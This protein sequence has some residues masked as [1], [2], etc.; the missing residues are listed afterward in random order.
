MVYYYAVDDGIEM[1]VA[2]NIYVANAKIKQYVE[3]TKS[4]KH[5]LLYVM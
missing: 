1:V 4:V 5:E 2:P 3:D